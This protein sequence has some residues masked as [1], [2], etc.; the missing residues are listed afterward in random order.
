MPPSAAPH[1]SS[2]NFYGVVV[3]LMMVGV[4]LMLVLARVLR[5]LVL[6]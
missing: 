1:I 4:A 5:V 6:L 3:V 2:K